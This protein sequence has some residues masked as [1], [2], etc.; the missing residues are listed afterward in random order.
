MKP[1]K[2]KISGIIERCCDVKTFRLKLEKDV[3]YEAGQYL[4][5]TL[6][7]E[8]QD[9]TKVFSISSS[10]T[11][12]G[13]IEFTKKIT[14][15]KFSNALNKLSVGR[16]VFVRLP[17]GNFTIKDAYQKIAFLSGGIGI[18]PIR[19]I[20]KN[21]TDLKISK[22]FILLYSNRNPDH[23]IFKDDFDQMSLANKNLKVFY[24]VTGDARGA[25]GFESGCIDAG[26]VRE[27]ISDYSQRVFLVCGPPGMVAAMEHILREEL[28]LSRE[29]VV[30]E[31][32]VG[33]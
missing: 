20:L 25:C 15:S 21:A 33:Y 13:Y 9:I 22:D 5:V 16:E 18:T 11:E 12:K 19:S 3:L 30:K 26:M 31:N 27:K 23:I 17:M 4:A 8:G 2:L 6:N 32:F 7:V 28:G 14:E 29:A 1:L 24:T 10:P